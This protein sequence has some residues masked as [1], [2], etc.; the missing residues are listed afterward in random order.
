M[1]KKEEEKQEEKK[2]T[3]TEKYFV[4]EVPTQ[5]APMIIDSKTEEQYTIELA[6]VKVMNDLEELKQGLLG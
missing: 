3:K 2:E 1:V 4:G 6:L 5:T